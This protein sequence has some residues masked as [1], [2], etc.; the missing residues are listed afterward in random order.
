MF[1]LGVEVITEGI[2][3]VVGGWWGEETSTACEG[4]EVMS[5][6][7]LGALILVSFSYQLISGFGGSPIDGGIIGAIS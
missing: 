5:W 2:M 4:V 7:K 3:L 6:L 1:G